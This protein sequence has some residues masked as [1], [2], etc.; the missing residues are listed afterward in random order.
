MNTWTTH[1]L[2]ETGFDNGLKVIFRW[3]HG[4]STE[5]VFDMICNN[6]FESFIHTAYHDDTLI[7]K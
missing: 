7:R 5:V 2:V 6:D 1:H 4:Q 3:E